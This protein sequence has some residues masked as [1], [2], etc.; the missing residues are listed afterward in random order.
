MLEKINLG[1]NKAGKSKERKKGFRI[2]CRDRHQ[3]GYF[4]K[5]WCQDSMKF[6][7]VKILG[8]FSLMGDSFFKT[9]NHKNLFVDLSKVHEVI[10]IFCY[11]KK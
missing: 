10:C 4:S 8:F 5:E 1:M 2:R 6:I 9:L 11:H 7:R 3:F